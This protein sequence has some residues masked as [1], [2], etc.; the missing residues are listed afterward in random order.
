MTARERTR[1]LAA[2]FL[3]LHRRPEGFVMPN[4]WDPG[5]AIL[6]AAEGFPALAST[7]AGVAFAHGRPDYG[8]PDGARALERSGMLAAL[9]RIAASV[10]LPV[11]ADLEAGYGDAPET[12]AETVTLAIAAGCAGGNIEDFTGDPATPLYEE[13]LAVERIAAARA[14][15]EASGVPF[16][17]TARCDALIFDPAG[18]QD[19]A[20][21]RLRRYADAGAD[22][23]YAPGAP[24]LA[25]IRRL[26]GETA[27]P[28]NVV[29]GLSG[30]PQTV[31]D[32]F[33]AGVHRI[34]VGG[35]IARAALGFVRRALVEIRDEG[36]FTYADGQIPQDELNRLYAAGNRD[37]A[38]APA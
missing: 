21:R 34:S 15:I 28:L 17:L 8:V 4:A 1:R 29:M 26:A 30:A 20:V 13:A 35:S 22:C 37:A 16:V 6:F 3:D 27:R 25:A 36:R 23:L 18:G 19:E 33:A 38:A 5:S 32:L 7:S 14:A 24:D 10:D 9:A 11:N 2:D 12:V 31:A